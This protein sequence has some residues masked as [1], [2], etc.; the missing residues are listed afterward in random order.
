MTTCFAYSVSLLIAND[1]Q[2][3]MISC[4]NSFFWVTYVAYLVSALIFLSTYT[5]QMT[6]TDRLLA[7]NTLS[8]SNIDSGLCF[9]D[10]FL[11]NP[12]KAALIPLRS[13]LMVSHINKHSLTK[14]VE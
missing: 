9:L 13:L 14:K 10:P 5:F 2:C 4:H 7:Y 11:L 8:I 1:K 12:T 6:F 3:F